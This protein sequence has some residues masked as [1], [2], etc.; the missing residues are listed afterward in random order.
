MV[1]VAAREER[2]IVDEHVAVACHEEV[3]NGYLPGLRSDV[4]RPFIQWKQVSETVRAVPIVFG[5]RIRLA[6][7]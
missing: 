2:L 5:I 1:T 4:L 7:F 6:V 3:A